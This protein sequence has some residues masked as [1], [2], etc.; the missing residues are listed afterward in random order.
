MSE[1]NVLTL[2][3][4]ATQAAYRASLQPRYSDDEAEIRADMERLFALGLQGEKVQLPC[5]DAVLGERKE[6][7][8][9]ALYD[10]LDDTVCFSL[11]MDVFKQSKCPH[12]AALRGALPKAWAKD[13]ADV[14]A[15]QRR[16]EL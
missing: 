13:K 6:S 2:P 16:G 12:V 4:S 7:F 8:V 3:V 5:A 9:F 14:L 10:A 15:M 11:L 1:A